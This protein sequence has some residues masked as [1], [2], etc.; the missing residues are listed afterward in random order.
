MAEIEKTA[1]T[2]KTPATAPSSGDWFD[3]WFADWPWPHLR[4]ELRRTFGEG[5]DPLRVE[6]FTEGDEAVVP[7]RCPV[8]TPTRT[9]R[10]R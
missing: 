5:M 1:Q 4:S 6:E 10:S 2:S 8:S 3:R 7:R 9:Y